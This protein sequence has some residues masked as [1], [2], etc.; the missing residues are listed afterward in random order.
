M[1]SSLEN[2]TGTEAVS[3]LGIMGAI[4]ATGKRLSG[5]H[6]TNGEWTTAILSDLHRYADG[7]G[8]R[9]WTTPNAV[10]STTN[11]WL[12]D[13]VISEGPTPQDIARVLVA[14]ECA[15]DC[16]FC[17]I[18]CDFLKLVQSRSTLRVMIFQSNDVEKT[19]NGLIEIVEV[20]KMSVPG[21]QYL[22]VRWNGQDGFT[23][24]SHTK[25]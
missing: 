7:L 19:T 15:W 23:F 3:E 1:S 6:H 22:F 18:K 25:S 4:E 10:D 21:D 5:R 14:V 24:T 2:A 16:P 13:F 8:L 12:Y 11:K 9:V 17:K 20:S